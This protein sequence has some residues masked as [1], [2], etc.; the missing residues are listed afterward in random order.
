M[1]TIQQT[2][3]EGLISAIQ[4]WCC[5][6][7]D[8]V[9][10]GIGDDAAVFRTDEDKVMLITT[11]ML[12]EH[13]HF[14]P[15]FPSPL[16]LG[17]KSLAVNL[18]D[19]A[20]MGGIPNYA[21]YSLGLPKTTS[22]EWIKKLYSGALQLA[23]RNCVSI[24]GGDTCRSGN[25]VIIS[26]TVTGECP[27]DQILR[28]SDA[29][30]GDR[31]YV[32]GNLGSSAAGLKNYLVPQQVAD[33]VKEHLFV[34]HCRPVP[35]IKEGRVLASSGLVNAVIDIS[36]GLSTDLGHICKDSKTGAKIFKENIP[37]SPELH[38]YCKVEGK[39][40]LD[41][42][43]YGGE[44]YALLFTVP[45]E[46]AETL[47]DLFHQHQLFE[48]VCIG[49]IIEGQKINLISPDGESEFLKAG[50]FSHFGEKKEL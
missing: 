32:T 42:A 20:A 40:P 33:T 28:R 48:P 41:Y 36:D 31:I 11:D 50:G 4:T 30:P 34:S 8:S 16:D 2:G 47:V 12:I 29:L 44:D 7:D 9:I 39:N 21:F 35:C 14:L 45:L 49:E 23:G 3:E 22:E 37:I 46:D 19:I 18:S 38:R 5:K 1:N 26:V 24:L 17:Y 27:P 10:T 13:V 6:E 15:Q 25:E 43:I